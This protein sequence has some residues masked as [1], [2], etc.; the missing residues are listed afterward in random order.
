MASK[1]TPSGLSEDQK[2]KYIERLIDAGKKALDE[3]IPI[4][5]ENIQKEEIRDEETGRVIKTIYQGGSLKS[6]TE[7]KRA[8]LEDCFSIVETINVEQNKLD[9]SKDTI[10]PLQKSVSFAEQR[11]A[12]NKRGR[13]ES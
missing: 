10:N 6:L 12:K 3:L 13:G 11:A 2:Q 4:I 1:K 5:E 9:S 8:T 7:L